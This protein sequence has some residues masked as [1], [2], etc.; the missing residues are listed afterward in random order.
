MSSFL[1]SNSKDYNRD[2]M[3]YR[4]SKRVLGPTHA[5]S[6]ASAQRYSKSMISVT[7]CF[8]AICSVGLS[9]ET[10]LGYPSNPVETMKSAQYSFMSF[11]LPLLDTYTTRN[12]VQNAASLDTCLCSLSQKPSKFDDRHLALEI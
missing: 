3:I 4:C 10:H 12:F 6:S 9:S 8:I 11:L 5:G 2:D 1:L 7:W